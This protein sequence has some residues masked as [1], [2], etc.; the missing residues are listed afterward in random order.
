M[1]DKRLIKIYEKNKEEISQ[2]EIK[3]QNGQILDEQKLILKRRLRKEKFKNLFT[4]V[5]RKLRN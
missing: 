5:S 2:K 4:S 1:R 3:K